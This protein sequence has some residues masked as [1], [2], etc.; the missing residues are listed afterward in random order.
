MKLFF[1]SLRG[2]LIL[3]V[4]CV[5]A[6]MM[7]LFICDSIV[8]QR[9]M[10]LDNQSE[11]TFAMARS[12]STSAAGWIASNDIAGLQE[13]V[14]AQRRYPEML[15]CVFTNETGH[16]L[17]NTDK[18][19]VG[20]YLL[21]LPK[22]SQETVFSRTPVLVDLAVPALLGQRHVGW[23]RIGI[24]Q[25]KMQRKLTNITLIGALYALGAIAVGSLVA[26]R[27]GFLITRRLYAVQET[28]CRVRDGLRTARCQIGG[29]DEAAS[30][31]REFN[32]M[33]D[34]LHEREKALQESETR[35]KQQL[36]ELQRMQEF[37]LEREDRVIA[38]KKE[39]NQLLVRLDEP[40]RYPG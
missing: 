37:M 14:E 34:N 20:L 4:A 21:D 5:H 39:V 23:V 29:N 35:M 25:N 1:G 22:Q 30:I 9:E 12:L 3:S 38:L 17:A 7:T 15:F 31:A 18:S 2:R 10:L 6:I 28:M 32:T 33:L 8:R 27:M 24:G 40:R 16:V 26:W 36:L 11:Q 13:I 19:K